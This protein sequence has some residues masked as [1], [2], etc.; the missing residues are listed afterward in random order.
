[1]YSPLMTRPRSTLPWRIQL[2][3]TMTPDNIPA[4]ALDRSNVIAL[5]APMA[6]ATAPLIVGSSHLVSPWNFV[7]LQLI[8]TS[9]DSGATADRLRQSK[10]SSGGECV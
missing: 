1:M 5:V 9:S 6:C 10:R 2:L 8:T 7:M 4:H 3:R